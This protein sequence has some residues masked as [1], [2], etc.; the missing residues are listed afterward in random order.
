M[1]RKI[2][3]MSDDDVFDHDQ[4]FF[5]YLGLEE[6]DVLRHVSHVR[7]NPSIMAITFQAFNGCNE[8][9]TV[10]L[11]ERLEEIWELAFRACTLLHEIRIPNVEEN[12]KEHIL[13]YN[14]PS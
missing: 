13:T 1:P 11:G 6:R 3:I 7:V 4:A 2:V 5:I 12:P 10:D 14:R 9:I 8:S